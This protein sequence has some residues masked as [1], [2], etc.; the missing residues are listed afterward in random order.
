MPRPVALVVSTSRCRL[1]TGIVAPVVTSADEVLQDTGPVWDEGGS[2]DL[3]PLSGDLDC[4]LCVVGLGGSGLSAVREGLAR[5]LDVVGLDAQGVAS[6]AAGRNGGFLL[7]GIA[8]FHHDAVR[9]LGGPRATALYRATLAEVDAMWR[10]MPEHVRRTGS[11]RIAATEDELEDCAAQLEQM[12]ADGL[13]VETYSGPEG[14][15]LLFPDD[16]VCD[17][18]ARC[19]TLARR[20]VADGARLFAHTTAQRVGPTAVTT[21]RGVVRCRAVVVAVD[22]GL[23]KVLPELKGVV[24]TARLQMLATAPT[25]EVELPRPVYRRYGY[26]YYQQLPTGRIAIGGFRDVAGDGEW[27]HAASPHPN[28]QDRLTS[29]VRDVLGVRVPI[30]HRW[31]ARVGYSRGVLPVFA[32]LRDGVIAIGGYSGTGNV[33][34]AILGRE[35]VA[36]ALHDAS[37]VSG[38]FDLTDLDLA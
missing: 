13:P 22:G 29:F 37:G 3:E 24:R 16:A 30:T 19:R 18:L 20:A 38:L 2:L 33:V 34:G 4:D 5:G 10:D 36:A 17:P 15:G 8:A 6:G 9:A 26:E 21:D 23:E 11:L 27:T 7:A 35:A 12:R 14:E 28:V 32:R 25:R 1:R 31:A